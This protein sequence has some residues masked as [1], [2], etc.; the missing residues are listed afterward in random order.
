[1]PQAEASIGVGTHS[2]ATSRWAVAASC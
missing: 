1:L 2:P